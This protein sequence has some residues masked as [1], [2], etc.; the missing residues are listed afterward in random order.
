MKYLGLDVGQKR[1]GIAIGE[2]LASELLTLRAG[3]HEAFYKEPARTRAFED[4]KT[5][6]EEEGVAGIVAGLPVKEDGSASE[7]SAKIASFCDGLSTVLGIAVQ[8]VDETLSSY[9]ARD[10][11]SSQGLAG[12]ELEVRLDQASAALILQ[13]Y[14]EEHAKI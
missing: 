4:I 3:Q 10:I 2:V 11:L 12:K 1:I 7:E 8:T 5:I 13:Q 14:L 6:V 9:M